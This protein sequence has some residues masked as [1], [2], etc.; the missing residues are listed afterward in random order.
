M[1]LLIFENPLKMVFPGYSKM[2]LNRILRTLAQARVCPAESQLGL[3]SLPLHM[4]S[5]RGL[6]VILSPLA[7]DDWDI[8]P[9]LRAHG[10]QGLLIC[11]D[12][13]DF[14]LKTF[15]QDRAGLLG[16]R[17]A[18]VERRLEL[19]KIAQLR[20]RVIDWRVAEPLSP[21]VYNAFRQSRGGRG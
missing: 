12:P 11:P 13:F 15:A 6:L 8:F 18:R 20:I 1:S 3:G 2:Q 10:N 21:L 14:A 4:F 7:S 9:R 5:S 19:R 17:A 16:L